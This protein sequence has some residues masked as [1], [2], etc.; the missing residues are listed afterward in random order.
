[1][2]AFS[3]EFIFELIK[4][5][6]IHL[7]LRILLE[8]DFSV[9]ILEE[10]LLV[11]LGEYLATRSIGDLLEQMV[12]VPGNGHYL[13]FANQFEFT[14]VVIEGRRGDLNLGVGLG[15]TRDAM[16]ADPTVANNQE[17]G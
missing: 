2:N 7:T 8:G 10:E 1:M 6:R 9:D 14:E 17:H 12:A 3:I 15:R 13:V 4:N 11:R 16:M 5:E